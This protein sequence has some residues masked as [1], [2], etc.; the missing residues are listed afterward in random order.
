MTDLIVNHAEFEDDYFKRAVAEE[1]LRTLKSGDAVYLV[2]YYRD[3]DLTGLL[4]SE[5][6]PK[7]IVMESYIADFNKGGQKVSEHIITEVIYRQFLNLKRRLIQDGVTQVNLSGTK[8]RSCIEEIYCL[9]TG[10]PSL[11]YESEYAV[12]QEPRFIRYVEA[13]KN[14]GID[15]EDLIRIIIKPISCNTVYPICR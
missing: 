12:I 7:L 15:E 6:H 1:M 3:S 14:L 4:P 2:P 13:A 5:K 8:R 9:L 11:P 10:L